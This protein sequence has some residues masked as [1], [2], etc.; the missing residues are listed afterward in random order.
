MVICWTVF[1]GMRGVSEGC[2][3]FGG[4]N[5]AQIKRGPNRSRGVLP[6]IALSP[7]FCRAR[8]ALLNYGGDPESARDLAA[9]Q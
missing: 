8:D 7:R 6:E 5:E 4:E 9:A 2:A 3:I 1:V